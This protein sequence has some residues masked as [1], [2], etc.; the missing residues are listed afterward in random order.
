MVTE[1]ADTPFSSL[2]PARS[3]ADGTTLYK[4]FSTDSLGEEAI[5]AIFAANY[6]VVGMFPWSAYPVFDP[7]E[8][9]APFKLAEGLFYNNAIETAASC[10]E[11]SAVSAM[12]TALLV[13]KALNASC[14]NW[15]PLGTG[16]N[17]AEL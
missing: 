9:F 13:Q 4:L 14:G 3:F 16:N 7:P 10:M 5:G 2:A 1:Q 8:Q 17:L 6:T 12:N 11:I 15:N